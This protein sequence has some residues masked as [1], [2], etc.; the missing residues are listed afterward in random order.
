MP[1][2][3]LKLSIWLVLHIKLKFFLMA[4][5]SDSPLHSHIHRLLVTLAFLLVPEQA[6]A[7]SHLTVFAFARLS[8]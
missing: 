3:S 7:L 5:L 4:L 8:T 6:R 1:L 2:P